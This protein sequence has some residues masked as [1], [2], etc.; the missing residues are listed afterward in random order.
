MVKFD[1]LIL[2]ADF[3]VLYMEE[4]KYVLIILGRPFLATCQTVIDVQKEELTMKVQDQEVTFKFFK[5]MKFLSDENEEECFRIDVVDSIIQDT[6]TISTDK[7]EACITNM[8]DSELDVQILECINYL[9]KPYHFKSTP[10]IE[11][12]ELLKKHRIK[13][14]IEEPP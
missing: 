10:P 12:L 7:L 5:A 1:K 13:P 8:I 2:P 11:S 4:D 3:I 9:E 14:S 6:N